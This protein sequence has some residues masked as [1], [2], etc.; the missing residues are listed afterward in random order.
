MIRKICLEHVRNLYNYRNV[1][2]ITTF[3][4]RPLPQTLIALS[5]TKGKEYFRDALAEGYMESFF[6]LSEQFI[7]QSEPSFCSLSS[8]AMVL[9]AL[10]HDPKKIWKGVWRWVTEEMLQCDSMK[11]CGHSLEKVKQDGMDFNSFENM[12]RCKI[13]LHYVC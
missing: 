2:Y 10:N 11:I 8:L 6:P 12:A 1:N 9:N 5:S 13:I 7:T 3:H 4:K